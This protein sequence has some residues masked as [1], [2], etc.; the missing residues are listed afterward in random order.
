MK[1]GKSTLVGTHGGKKSFFRLRCGSWDCPHCGPKRRARLKKQAY[2]GNPNSFLTLTINPQAFEDPASAARGLVISFRRMREAICKRLSQRA[3]P[4]LAVFEAT[5]NGWPH[6]HIL[7]RCSYVDQK[8]LSDYMR[9]RIDSPIVHIE[10]IK[11]RKRLAVYIS[12]YVAKDPARF[13]GSKRTWRNQRYLG[14]REKKPPSPWQWRLSAA[15]LE[16][17]AWHTGCHES[18]EK[19]IPAEGF[20]TWEPVPP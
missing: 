14:P 16:A 7:M 8:W 12:K 10:R 15:T 13:E 6:L 9:R 18:P 4:F 20:S 11:S 3:I 5:K 19:P 2:V 1:C 17:W